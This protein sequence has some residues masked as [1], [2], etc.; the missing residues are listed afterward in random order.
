MKID[1]KTFLTL[2]TLSAGVITAHFMGIKEAKTYTD[3]E[4]SELRESSEEKMEKISEKI[5]SIKETVIRIKTLL[6]KEKIA[7]E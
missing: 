2:L 7:H 1:F 5:D 3:K 6:E 4:I